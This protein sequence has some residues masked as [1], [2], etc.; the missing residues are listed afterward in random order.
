MTRRFLSPVVVSLLWACLPAG[1]AAGPGAD[2]AQVDKSDQHAQPGKIPGE[3]MLRAR[4]LEVKP[5]GPV[6][7]DWRWG[8]EG[9][10]GSVYRGILGRQLAVG[11]WSPATPLTT[12][13]RARTLKQPYWYITFTVN[14]YGKG[15]AY[16]AAF[17]PGLE[18]SATIRDAAAGPDEA[19]GASP[20]AGPDMSR[21]FDAVRRSFIAAPALAVT[22][23]TVEPSVPVVEGVLL[24]NPSGKHSVVLM[25]WAYRQTATSA[26]GKAQAA[27]VKLKDVEVIVRG[28]GEMKRARSARLDQELGIRRDGEALRFTLPWLEEGDVVAME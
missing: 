21:D 15:K 24:R 2:T 25:N 19:R 28:A 11:E 8:G 6:Q 7:I 5:A 12:L 10:G 17:Y 27:H 9:L 14:A 23:P 1:L 16:V 26:N 18:Y 20:Q 3:L 4:V 13:A 22:Q